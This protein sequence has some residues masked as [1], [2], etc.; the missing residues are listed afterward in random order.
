MKVILKG[1]AYAEDGLLIYNALA[2]WV[3]SYIGL[4][5]DDEGRDGKV[6]LSVL[7]STILICK[8]GARS[9]ACSAQSHLP[10]A[11]HKLTPRG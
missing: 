2:R 11:T 7:S 4:Y 3:E 9:L 6:Q 5:Y 8:L 1:Y 10:S